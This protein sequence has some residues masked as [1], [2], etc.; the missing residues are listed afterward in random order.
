MMENEI[1]KP[2]VGYE[3]LY[4]V[5]NLGRVRSLDRYAKQPKGGLRLIKGRILNQ[6]INRCGYLFVSLSK[7]GKVKKITIH[8]LV[9]QAFIPNPD[10]LPEV[11]HKDECKTNNRAD[12]LEYCTR[13]YNL[14]YGTGNSRRADKQ[15]KPVLQFDLQGNFIK[16]WSSLI[17]AG[18]NG[19][20]QGNISLCCQGKQKFHKGFIWKY[21]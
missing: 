20:G 1:W 14:Y 16:E 12:N 11:N 5:S 10:N 9:A 3:G 2:V 4:E 19:F 6:Y 15:S 7:N 13:K 17:E 8:R 18:R 21:K